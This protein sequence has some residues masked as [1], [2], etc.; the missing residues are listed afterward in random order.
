MF[1]QGFPRTSLF[2]CRYHSTKSPE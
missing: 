1:E 2:L